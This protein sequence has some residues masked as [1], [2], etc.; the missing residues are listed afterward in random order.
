MAFIKIGQRILTAEQE[1]FTA[2]VSCIDTGAG[3]ILI[4]S[5]CFPV[6]IEKWRGEIAKFSQDEISYLINTDFHWDHC[7][8]N[9]RFTTNVIAHDL[10]YTNIA[11]QDGTG[12]RMLLGP[13]SLISQE[14]KDASAQ[15]PP[16]LP[17]I[18]FSETMYLH[19]GGVNLEL[20][21][22]GGH[23]EGTIGIRVVDEGVFFSGDNIVSGMHPFKL[24]ADVPQWIEAL[25]KIQAMD[26][27]T[28]VPGHGKV[29]GKE[30]VGIVLHYFEEMLYRVRS[31][32]EIGYSQ[33]ETVESLRSMF[34]FFPVDERR[35]EQIGRFFDAGTRRLY[36]QII[37]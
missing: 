14:V 6:D 34:Y 5:P 3:L 15:I 25:K 16:A 21:Y 33:D 36:D 28:I 29:C 12:F 32:K 18:T 27:D 26:I 11:K 19:P 10:T 37:F 4:D 7:T 22:M 8:G 20:L 1:F 23:T 24:Q 30:Q 9:S 31:L 13:N 2:N 17:R 35:V